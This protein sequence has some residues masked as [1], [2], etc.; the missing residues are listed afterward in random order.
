MPSISP[1]ASSSSR[2]L[3][4]GTSES[5]KRSFDLL[6][7]V[8]DGTCVRRTPQQQPTH[9][10]ALALTQTLACPLLTLGHT[11]APLA[12]PQHTTTMIGMRG[13]TE[14]QQQQ[15]LVATLTRLGPAAPQLGAGSVLT[16]S[17]QLRLS[18][19]QLSAL[20]A[21]RAAPQGP[22]R[23]LQP[24]MGLS[25]SLMG[26]SAAA[27]AAAAAQQN[28]GICSMSSLSPCVSLL[29]LGQ[30]QPLD[31]PLQDT[32][33][34]VLK[35]LCLISAFSPFSSPCSSAVSL[36]SSASCS[37]CSNSSNSSSSC[38]TTSTAFVAQPQP[39]T[40]PLAPLP[41]LRPQP[42]QHDGD[43]DQLWVLL[44]HVAEEQR[45]HKARATWCIPGGCGAVCQMHRPLACAGPLHCMPY[46]T[47]RS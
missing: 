10:Q 11:C 12:T 1:R 35:P 39:Q 29:P 31:T 9:T 34:A 45:L 15:Q 7:S 6:W 18:C 21:I 44:A 28:A 25:S 4:P 41:H 30:L 8:V 47:V 5:F 40:T 13:P 42:P 23:E 36:C 32:P 46:L 33:P 20:Q 24:L 16:P 43:M 19:G 3:P 37:T 14:Q 22:T 38:L 26:L 27:A 17:T 2:C